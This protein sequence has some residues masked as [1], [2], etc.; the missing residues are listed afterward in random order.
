MKRKE[1]HCTN[2]TKYC[3]SIRLL[4]LF[5][6]IS[7]NNPIWAN[8]S[9]QDLTIQGIITDVETQQPLQGVSI[10][11]KEKN[12]TVTT[13]SLGQYT[14]T[15]AANDTLL[16]RFI[17]YVTREVPINGNTEISVALQAS[18]EN[19]DEVVVVGYGTQKRSSV[20][21]AVSAV[22]GQDIALKPV[23]DLSNSLGGRVPGV[24]FTQ[25]SGEPGADMSS[26][27]IRGVSTTGNTQP[28]VI[29]DGIPRDFSRL[30][31][32][33]IAS[34]SVL[35][36]AAAVAPY[37]MAGANGV[38]LVTTKQGQKGAPT[39]SYDA[40]FA[41]QNPTVLTKFADA[42]QY[43]T[44]FNMA[45]DNVGQPHRFSSYDLQMYREGSDP[46]RY[47]DHNVLR[48][49]ITPNSPMTNHHL[50][51]TGGAEKVNYYVGLNYLYQGG[52]WETTNMHQY[53]LISKIDAQA[54]P[55]TKINLSI[56]GR[57]EQNNY[58]GVE[59]TGA[60]NIF[61]Q[62]F[63]TPPIAPLVYPG[64]LA[65]EYE[66]R[67]VYGAIF[68]SGFRKFRDYVLLNQ[69]TIEQQLPFIPGLSIKGVVAYDLS[70]TLNKIWRTP[71]PY[72]T[73]D[74][75]QTPYEYREAGND[76]PAK[77]IYSQDYAE[78]HAFT[79]QG[80]LNYQNTFGKHDLSG[81]MVFE[82]R[83]TRTSM[84][85]ASRNNYNINIPELDAGSSDPTDMSNSG[86]SLEAKQ[87]S[88]IYRLSYNYDNRYL[89]ETSGR[90]D[91]NYYFAPGHRFGFFPSAS[92]G[93]R[94]SEEAFFKRGLPWIS[95]L[96]LRG[97]YGESGA[98]AGS[99]FQ[100]LS[101]YTLYGNS[102]VI[103][104]IPTQGIYETIEPNP[105]ITWERAQKTNIGFDAAFLNNQLTF[106]AEYFYERRNNMLLPPQVTVP[107]EYGI[108]IAQVN[109]GKMKNNGVE[110]SIG[111]MHTFKN[112]LHISIQANFTYAKNELVQV[113]ETSTTFNNPG[114]RVTG[115]P[116]GTKFGYQALGYF[117]VEE[118]LNGNNVI[119]PDEY[120]VRQPWG[121]VHPGDLKY[122][123]TNGD[124][125]I[126]EHD[127]V[128]IGYPD[129]PQII[130]GFSPNI[131]Y[132]GFD[133]SLL[134]QGAANRDF[135]I[136]DV[137]AWP[138]TNGAS[139]PVT[140][141]DVWTPENPH[142]TN[143]RVTPQPT[144]N[145]TQYSSWW[146]QNA[147]YLRLKTGELGYT[148]SSEQLKSLKMQSARIYL[149]GQNILTWSKL[150]NFDPEISDSFGMFYPQ[151]R[152]LSLG[153]N[154][155]F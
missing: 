20:T 93:W 118:D 126:D 13:D 79:Y 120:P 132:K 146:L 16:I 108:S 109:E 89:L 77:P 137:G 57:I 6:I 48:E 37:G 10:S 130:Y 147:S 106:T 149:S 112:D 122:Q 39:L 32:H 18:A 31:P 30:D 33:S 1:P 139:V 17:G 111:G 140:A 25:N 61:S 152:V 144:T 12:R 21:A 127:M 134:F 80:H 143:P 23:A 154:I 81:L 82:V 101:A 66:G 103:N 49:L 46:I 155:K 98:L 5:W 135:W 15:T 70:P 8:A 22:E 68:N 34:I 26:L 153:V 55:T 59:S 90:Y 116:L 131:R 110:L 19:L 45:N 42:Y 113:F 84:F 99:P 47:P 60:G 94:I 11:V 54:T 24:I 64:G 138:F 58:P 114:R 67:T 65:G 27:F 87:R 53:N 97:S 29:V 51:L 115:R 119:D 141:L 88:F 44:L 73:V 100:Y 36:D 2:F 148:F 69:L 96:K 121:P 102:A 117:Q 78:E 63:R 9:R 85:A 150:K 133:L 38:V 105:M 56:N 129:V 35:K 7:Y 95:D 86:S 72:Y 14:V 71:M 62:A 43:A 91:G 128:P 74:T 83:N 50:Q 76:G 41:W 92:I 52:M 125:Q 136:G 4:C 28:L 107:F 3:R 104:G 151:Q 145:N 123:D 40:Y 75:T 142:A 124:G